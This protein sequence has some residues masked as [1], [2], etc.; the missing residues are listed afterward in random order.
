MI[1][2]ITE[3]ILSN[4]NKI[5]N[6][7]EKLH[8]YEIKGC[9]SVE[10]KKELQL[11]KNTTEKLYPLM[12]QLFKENQSKI[13][14]ISTLASIFKVTFLPLLK[15]H[16]LYLSQINESDTNLLK[17]QSRLAITYLNIDGSID[18]LRIIHSYLK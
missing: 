17:I 18:N 8:E 12:M 16:L 5:V 6:S 9:T 7:Y 3:E 10:I 4:I 13:K 14:G 2:N 11:L 15:I 1:K